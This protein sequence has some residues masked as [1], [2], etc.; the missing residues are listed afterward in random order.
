[1]LYNLYFVRYDSL[2]SQMST[3][4]ISTEKHQIERR[5][6]CP[7]RGPF[8]DCQD[9]RHMRKDEAHHVRSHRR[10]HKSQRT[11][12]MKYIE[13]AALRGPDGNL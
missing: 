6:C 10:A 12:V 8:N 4:H 3:A 11:G 2:L 1:M 7:Q 5:E 9:M 13:K